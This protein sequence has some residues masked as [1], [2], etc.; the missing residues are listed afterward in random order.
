MQFCPRCRS[1]L[2]LY[3]GKR[4]YV[5]KCPRGDCAAPFVIFEKNGQAGIPPR[6]TIDS[7]L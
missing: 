3:E 4:V 5:Y 6:A 7:T 1:P 2:E